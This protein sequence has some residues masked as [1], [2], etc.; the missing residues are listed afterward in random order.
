MSNLSRAILDEALSLPDQDRIKLLEALLQSLD[1]PD[2]TIDS[3]I[4]EEAT[5]RL[6]AYRSGQLNTVSLEKVLGKYA[7]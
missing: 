7:Q 1:K 4:A 3:L 5:S 6:E 2:P